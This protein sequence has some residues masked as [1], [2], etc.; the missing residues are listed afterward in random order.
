MKEYAYLHPSHKDPYHFFVIETGAIRSLAPVALYLLILSSATVV[1]PIVVSKAWAETATIQQAGAPAEPEVSAVPEAPAE[2]QDEQTP[3]QPVEDEKNKAAP[4]PVEPNERKE[5]P[6]VFDVLHG[7]LS[8]GVISTATWL[9]SFFGDERYELEE[10]RT[11]VK[12]WYDA[13]READAKWRIGPEVDLRLVLPQ[14][15]RRTRL[16]IAGNPIDEQYPAL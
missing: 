14:F 5:G 9:D 3:E 4:A 7:A 8:K 15:K 2:K 16:I 1:N 11:V 10:N 12:A 13:F 6:Y